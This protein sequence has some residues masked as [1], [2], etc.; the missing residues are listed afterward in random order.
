MVMTLGS[1]I[2]CDNGLGSVRDVTLGRTVVGCGRGRRHRCWVGAER[3]GFF[4]GRQTSLVDCEFGSELNRTWLSTMAIC[5]GFEN[6][7]VTFAGLVFCSA[8]WTPRVSPPSPARSRSLAAQPRLDFRIALVKQ[9]PE[10]LRRPAVQRLSQALPRSLTCW[11]CGDSGRRLRPSARGNSPPN[12]T[13][14]R[15]PWSP[16]SGGSVGTAWFASPLIGG[17][18]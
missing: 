4:R 3:G 18:C 9:C 7:P 17:Q 12:S 10:H 5:L 6:S 11:P 15:P 16:P 8:G 1:G 13:S 14:A 2:G